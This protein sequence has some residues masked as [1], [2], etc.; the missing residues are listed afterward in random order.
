MTSP[1]NTVFLSLVVPCYNEEA[2][3]PL[4]YDEAVKTEPSING[5]CELI[6][7]DDGSKDNTLKILRQLANQDTRVRY[8][9]FS[10]NFG[11][12]AA[13]LAGLQ[14]AQ[15]KYVI[16][17]DADLQ[18]PPCLIPEM[19]EEITNGE[20]DCIVAKRTRKGDPLLQ[21]FFAKCFYLIISQL[22][23]VEIT[24]GVGDFRLMSKT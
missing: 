19:L 2:A 7:V 4:F 20:Y 15:G 11:K 18:H 6:F 24:D 13:M 22:I 5:Q 3:I 14:A 9:S 1:T 21:S 8:I 17:L 10:R 12:E 23:G 16:M